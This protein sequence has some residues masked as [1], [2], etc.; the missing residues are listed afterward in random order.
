MMK[1][2]IGKSILALVIAIGMILSCVGA[3][4][5]EK[6]WITAEDISDMPETTIRYWYYETP[7]RI[8]LGQK[9]VEEFMK[10]Y[11]NIKV[12]GSTAPDNTDNEMLLAYIKTQNHSSIQQSVNLSLIHIWC[13]QPAHGQDDRSGL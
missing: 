11:P 10:L 3:M 13:V 12:E 6:N 5:E 8:A 1:I 4:A 7:E 9:Q 2:R